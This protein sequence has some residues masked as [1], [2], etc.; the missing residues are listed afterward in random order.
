LC[1][2]SGRLSRL[3][4]CSLFCAAGEWSIRTL[5]RN[6]TQTSKKAGKASNH[7]TIHGTD[8]GFFC[9]G[10]VRKTAIQFADLAQREQIIGDRDLQIAATALSL[11]Y[12]LATL[13]IG[14]F[15]RVTSLRLIDVSSYV[16]V[17]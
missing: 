3:T 8:S 7:R 9:L 4:I 2:F 14:E 5:T 1:P 17:D 12:D 6:W 11:D 10:G 13:N 15:R 16:I